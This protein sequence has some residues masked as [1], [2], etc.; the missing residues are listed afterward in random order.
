MIFFSLDWLA[1]WGQL[2]GSD[3]SQEHKSIVNTE[4]T[5]QRETGS[6]S[7]YYYLLSIE[8]MYVD[9]YAFMYLFIFT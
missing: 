8:Y 9:R 5:L 2:L 3:S 6:K 4:T 7:G 1:I